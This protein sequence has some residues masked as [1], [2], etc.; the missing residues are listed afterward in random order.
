MV[1]L[2][3]LFFR[4]FFFMVGAL[5]VFLWFYCKFCF[6]VFFLWLGV[7][8]LFFFYLFSGSLD[9]HGDFVICFC[10]FQGCFY[11]SRIRCCV[12]N[13]VFLLF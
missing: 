4:M 12:S 6:L 7:Q 2:H 13:G 11:C 3:V 1:L 8:L 5:I 10:D 9:F